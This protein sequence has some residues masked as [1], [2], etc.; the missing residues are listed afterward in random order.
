[1]EKN[2]VYLFNN[3]GL[4]Y[5][6]YNFFSL[7]ALD[8]RKNQAGVDISSMTRETVFCG[9]NFDKHSSKVLE[10]NQLSNPPNFQ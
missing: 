4:I 6:T 9:N 3:M 1:M 10:S 8:D 2:M 7:P 5:K